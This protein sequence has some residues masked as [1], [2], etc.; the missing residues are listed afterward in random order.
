MIFFYLKLGLAVFNLLLS[1]VWLGS[2]FIDKVMG[3]YE[4]E[5]QQYVW[6]IFCLA[7]GLYLLYNCMM[8]LMTGENHV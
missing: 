1:G 7:V 8:Y 4:A 2:I 6:F 3:I 5:W